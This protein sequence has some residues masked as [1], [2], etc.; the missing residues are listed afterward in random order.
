MTNPPV[1][2]FGEVTD[3]CVARTRLFG[4]ANACFRRMRPGEQRPNFGACHNDEG[5][6]AGEGG[7]LDGTTMRR[8]LMFQYVFLSC[9]SALAA[10]HPGM[11]I[12]ST[13]KH[14]LQPDVVLAMSDDPLPIEGRRASRLQL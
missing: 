6:G 10:S 13:A 14:D 1:T 5:E 7:N 8:A 4:M 11:P 12:L 9:M 2:G 3:D